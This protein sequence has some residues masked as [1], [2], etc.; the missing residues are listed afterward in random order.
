MYVQKRKNR[1][2]IYYSFSYT[3]RAGKRVR[4]SRD[5]H[6]HFTNEAAAKEWARK[7][8]AEFEAE[9]A[10]KERRIGWRDKFYEFDTELV[11]IYE[12]YQKNNAPNSWSD[13][14]R[15]LRF[16]VLPWFLSEKAANNLNT[17]HFYRQE[18]RDYV[19]FHAKKL[20]SDELLSYS[21]K[22][23]V[24]H[25]LNTFLECMG[26][27]GKMNPDDVKLCEVFP[28]EKL[29]LKNHESVIDA[30]E[31]KEICSRLDKTSP[32]CR[33]F[34]Y[35]LYHT[36]LRHN[37]LLSVSMQM[38][39]SGEIVGP[40]GEELKKCQIQTHGYLVLTSQVQR[41]EQGIGARN[42]NGKLNRKPLKGRPKIDPAYDRI[43]PI[44]DKDCW[45]V[46]AKRWKAQ[47]LLHTQRVFGSNLDDYLLFEGCTQTRLGKDLN[48]AYK[49]TEFKKKTF[50][51]CRHSY[52]TNFV[53]QTR[54]FFLARQ[55]L[56]HKSDAFERYLH[57]YEKA[58]ILNKAK[59][60]KIELIS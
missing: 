59:E 12:N 16:Y 39:K 53:G 57:I 29:I 43:I 44:S 15:Y 17:W 4:L 41:F 42:E 50:H 51:D 6:P 18:F 31:L 8:S 3:D 46:L 33:D 14:V 48:A 19:E 47:E 54:S 1:H 40:I 9:T 60:G 25:A 37:E 13:S 10:K 22:N 21:S 36:G 38:L 27:Y 23:K 2:G 20:R 7:K 28:A 24:I 52:C 58:A 35:V 11:P 32:N 26:K 45:N 34:F 5:D 49:G 56:G 30:D 55:I